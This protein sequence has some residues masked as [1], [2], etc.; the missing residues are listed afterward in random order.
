M[1]PL[2]IMNYRAQGALGAH[3]IA[4]AGT[5]DQAVKQAAAGTDALLGVTTDVGGDDGKRVDVIH[6]GLAEVDFGA[7]VDYG[8]TLTADADGK[9]VPATPGDRVVGVAMCGGINNDLGLVLIGA[10]ATQPA[11]PA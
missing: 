2:L 7:S 1:K 4:A 3:R 6:T 11:E 9:A 10:G 5:E 8:A